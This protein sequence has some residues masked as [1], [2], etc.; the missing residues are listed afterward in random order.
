MKKTTIILIALLLIIVL[1]I[2][3]VNKSENE[4]INITNIDIV[5]LAEVDIEDSNSTS[6]SM[7]YDVTFKENIEIIDDETI[8]EYKRVEKYKIKYDE[9]QCKYYN[10]SF[11]IKLYKKMMRFQKSIDNYTYFLYP[12]GVSNKDSNI[13]YFLF[14]I[15]KNTNTIHLVYPMDISYFDI[16]DNTIYYLN[17]NHKLYA[18]NLNAKH[19]KLLKSTINRF[20][21]GDNKIFFSYMKDHLKGI[22]CMDLNAENEMKVV[23]H[24]EGL[25]DHFIYLDGYIY[26]NNEFKIKPYYNATEAP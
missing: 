15:E 11:P 23:K 24:I 17:C 6:S 10:Y 1:I 25:E 3:H 7:F 14:N 12:V 2:N 13:I 16:L 18:M 20:Q 26:I 21:L 22:Y 5:P 8:D 9:K 19:N 4:D